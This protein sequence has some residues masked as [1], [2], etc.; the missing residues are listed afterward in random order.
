MKRKP[1]FARI[2]LAAILVLSVFIPASAKTSH[3]RI[4]NAVRAV[5]DAQVA[6]WNR[7]DIDA[8]MNGYARSAKTIFIS[9]DSVTRGWQTVLD[10]YKKRYDS[11]DKM[12]TLVFSDLEITPLTN[13][14][15]VVLGS[16]RL[17]G[18]KDE[19]HGKFTLIFRN[20]KQGWRIIRDHTSSA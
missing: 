2:A 10:R 12:G 4:I 17:L 14:T 6:A 20:T 19:P 3:S 18:T 16:W 5:L 8:Y 11:R 7:G 9:G 13:D 15:A 1:S